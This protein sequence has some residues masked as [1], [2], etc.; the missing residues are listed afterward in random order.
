MKAINVVTMA[1]IISFIPGCATYR[2]N[3]DVTFDSTVVKKTESEIQILEQGLA[4]GSYQSLGMIDGVVKKLTVFHKDPT[5]EQVNV[6]LIQKAQALHADA[7]INVTYKGGIGMTTWG[8]L[9]GEGEAVKINE[10]E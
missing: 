5:K 2:T 7:V 9:K 6:V 3:S 10:S 4:T 8:Y 1:L